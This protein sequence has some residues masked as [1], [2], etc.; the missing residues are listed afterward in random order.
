MVSRCTPKLVFKTLKTKKYGVTTSKIFSF[1]IISSSLF[2]AIIS[3]SYLRKQSNESN[4]Y[5]YFFFRIVIIITG[6]IQCAQDVGKL[7]DNIQFFKLIESVVY[8]S[9]AHRYESHDESFSSNFSN[10]FSVYI[11]DSNV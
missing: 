4:A 11:C 6:R 7:S 10:F 8:T 9:D 1:T 2:C 5:F 3:L